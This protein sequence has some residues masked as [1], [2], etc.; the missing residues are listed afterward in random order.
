HGGTVDK[1]VGDA[2]MA[3]WNAPLDDAQHALHATQAA[4]E[5]Q[6]AMRKLQP[7]FGG[8][9]APGLAMRVGLHSGPAIVGN[10]G[11]SL[12]FDYTAL[13][14]TVNLASRLEGANK[15]YGTPI[16]LSAAT[17][18]ALGDAVPMRVVDR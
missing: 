1:Y 4:L 15:Y 7:R 12:R 17:A 14:D 18:A 16:L 5:M 6:H 11:S 8:L 2:V 3:F 13:G 9:G 10:M